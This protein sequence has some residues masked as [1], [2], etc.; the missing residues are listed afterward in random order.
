[1]LS[2]LKEKN[3]ELKEKLG[4]L[5]CETTKVYAEAQK[6]IMPNSKDAVHAELQKLG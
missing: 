5:R 3:K 2:D 1:M 6:L 4:K